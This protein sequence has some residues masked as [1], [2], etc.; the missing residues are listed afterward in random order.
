LFFDILNLEILK[1]Q[2]L[3]EEKMAQRKIVMPVVSFHAI[4]ETTGITIMCL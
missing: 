4:V 1:C 2:N 3:A